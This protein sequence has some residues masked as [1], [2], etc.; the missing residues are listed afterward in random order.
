[1]IKRLRRVVLLVVLFATL[2]FTA[3]AQST[4][5]YTVKELSVRLN[6]P[7]AQANIEIVGTPGSHVSVQLIL[8]G[9]NIADV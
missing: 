1:M 2:V 5:D 9:E 4:S 6:R 3:N 8:P 7:E